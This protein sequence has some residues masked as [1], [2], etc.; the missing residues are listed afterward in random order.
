MT[1]TDFCGYDD[2]F[3]GLIMIYDDD[4]QWRQPGKNRTLKKVFWTVEKLYKPDKNVF[5]MFYL[6]P[7]FAGF[8]PLKS[9][10]K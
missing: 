7:V 3:D 5:K 1:T 2:W 4:E 10:Q 8:W 9:A 6:R